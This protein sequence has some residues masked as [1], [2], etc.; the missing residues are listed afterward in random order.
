MQE[1]TIVKP[2]RC[3]L[4]TNTC[5]EKVPA[6]PNGTGV[7][8][9][10]AVPGAGGAAVDAAAVLPVPGLLPARSAPEERR[11][12]R[13]GDLPRQQ[14]RNLVAVDV[15]QRSQRGLERPLQAHLRHSSRPTRTNISV[16]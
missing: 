4:H 11:P 2:I 14:R 1:E 16:R 5:L 15:T 10:R 7:G 12:A 6:Q 9:G 8:G 3:E 13:A